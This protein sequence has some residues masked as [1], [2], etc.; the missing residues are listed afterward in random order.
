VHVEFMG[1]TLM[2]IARTR[3]AQCF[4]SG[5][6]SPAAACERGQVDDTASWTASATTDNKH[7]EIGRGGVLSL[8]DF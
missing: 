4:E 6:Q 7:D 8:W 1:P 3:Q 2:S 5:P